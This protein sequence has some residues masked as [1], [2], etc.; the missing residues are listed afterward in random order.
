MKED[1]KVLNE[2]IDAL[3]LT[4]TNNLDYYFLN[5]SKESLWSFINTSIKADSTL[6]FLKNLSTGFHQLVSIALAAVL[7]MTIDGSS[8]G[9]LVFYLFVSDM[10]LNTSQKIE[11]SIYSLTKMMPSFENVNSILNLNKCEGTEN[12]E[13][14]EF[15]DV[16]FYYECNQNMIMCKKNAM[17][18]K[19]DIIRV[20][21]LNGGGKSA[22]VKL[23]K[24][25]LYPKMRDVLLNGLSTKDISLNSLKD[26][27]LYIN[28]DEIILND[29]IKTYIEAIS[30]QKISDL[31]LNQLNQTV[32]F[33]D[34]IL[35]IAGNGQSLSGG[36]RKK[37]LM[38]KLLL[39]YK[40]A[41]VIILDEIEAGL[42]VETKNIVAQLEKEI[43]KSKSDCIFLNYT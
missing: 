16:D 1:N 6:V 23:I 28:Q 29:D 4:K 9:D 17:F 26:Q 13:T 14:I 15:K 38:I 5:K 18:R 41:S 43:I 22:F 7:S 20:T 24:G 2:Y 42:D 25:L 36:Q 30:G 32:V 21:G 10:I 27:I 19:G 37:L 35:R 39:K 34:S 3:E 31:E 11:S 12:I 8:A 40:T 33:D